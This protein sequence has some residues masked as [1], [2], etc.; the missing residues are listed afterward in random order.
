MKGRGY[1]CSVLLL[2]VIFLPGCEKSDVDSV[3]HFNQAV[4]HKSR[5]DLS[6]A[7]I[8]LKG[9]LQKK[10]DDMAARMMLGQIYVATGDGING[11]K[12]LLRARGAGA[13]GPLFSLY[14]AQAYIQENKYQE[15]L[16]NVAVDDAL[17]AT[18]RATLLSLRGRALLALGDTDGA[19]SAMRS[20][21]HY[22]ADS[23]WVLYGQAV[24]LI[25]QSA[26]DDAHSA[27]ERALNAP[28]ADEMRWLKQDVLLL[29]GALEFIQADYVTA[30]TTLEG[31]LKQQPDKVITARSHDARIRLIWALLA[32]RDWKTAE[33]H[34]TRLSNSLRRTPIIKYF[35][36]YIAYEKGEYGTARDY[37]GQALK[38]NAKHYP[39]VLLMGAV[40]YAMGLYEQADDYLTS[41]LARVPA[42]IAAHKLL[43]STRLK[44]HQP[45]LA[46]S[47]INP[48]LRIAPD[49]A[50]LLALLGS[51]AILDGD[52][53]MATNY[54]QQAVA[55]SPGNELFRLKLAEAYLA[56]GDTQD[57]ID[58]LRSS[59]A[60]DKPS[61]RSG[62][63]LAMTYARQG[64]MKKAIALA[65]ILAKEAPQSAEAQVLLATLH[66]R[67]GDKKRAR[68]C[69][70]Q[71]LLLNPRYSLPV[72]KLARMDERAGRLKSAQA[73]YESVLVWDAQNA[74][75]MLELAKIANRLGNEDLALSWL[76]RARR[77]APDSISSRIV[78]ARHY[79]ARGQHNRAL[80]LV[81]EAV[82]AAPEQA[83]AL[84]ALGAAQMARGT[85]LD[86]LLT[87]RK[88]TKLYPNSTS[89]RYHLANAEL[90]LGRVADAKRQLAKALELQPDFIAA[91]KLLVRVEL[92]QGDSGAAFRVVK[93]LSRQKELGG[94]D[95][96]LRGDIYSAQKKY[97]K[98]LKIYE[99][100]AK[101]HKLA[102]LAI[103][104]FET[105]QQLGQTKSAR[106][107]LTQ[108]LTMHPQEILVRLTL[109]SAYRKAGLIEDAVSHYEYVLKQSP[110][111]IYALNDLASLL[112]EIEPERSL[113]LAERAVSL[114]PNHPVL[115]DTLGWI[116]LNRG[117]PMR[118]LKLLSQAAER[119]PGVA[120]IRYHLAAAY[121]RS[122]S[123]E[124][125]LSTL[126][127]LL[128]Q[129]HDAFDS[130]ENAQ[131]LYERLK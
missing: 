49:D 51:A 34:I 116:L 120:D 9:A 113:A 39:S 62:A 82:A 56:E 41:F 36:G 100:T 60:G 40:S 74:G 108:W 121:A 99:A 91:A 105:R 127:A 103:K 17:P 129:P 64:N 6:S 48:A 26:Y 87:F 10:P 5:G 68:Q 15:L 31:V 85:Y 81:Q 57:A 12:E 50:E 119:A 128:A 14:L 80:E 73:R 96:I 90:K 55:A 46:M 20:A 54:Y 97:A 65:E 37:L 18:V 83:E 131:Q 25:S 94:K 3:D 79:S 7:I 24:L 104:I 16:D 27:I 8:E 77:A 112:I 33:V 75:I 28:I 32:L 38:I 84:L 66:E 126:E 63:L 13:V 23:V 29:R 69:Y 102:V 1:L 124:R 11:E 117:E 86:A 45:A 114:R 53:A 95:G 35:R 58:E 98:A 93:K 22:D 122:G 4:E 110:N 44:Q 52:G 67:A 72:V 59:F 47:A 109:A 111:N 61:L 2:L 123:R 19:Q 21:A 118:A 71:A 130:S 101:R 115:N 92:D 42:N 76:K 43:A 30:V 107:V 88:L 89:G 78:L 70:E 125:A 106:R